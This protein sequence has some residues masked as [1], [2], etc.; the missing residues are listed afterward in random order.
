VVVRPATPGAPKRFDPERVAVEFAGP[1]WRRDMDPATARLAE[2]EL[3]E[4]L[5]EELAARDGAL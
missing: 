2:I 3:E 1:A 5:G 4:A